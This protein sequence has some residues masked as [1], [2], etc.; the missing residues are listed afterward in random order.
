MTDKQPQ[1]GN[2]TFFLGFQKQFPVEGKSIPC[3]TVKQSQETKKPALD[4]GTFETVYE[5]L[6]YDHKRV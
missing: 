6:R 3:L 5:K 1:H 4:S 2:L